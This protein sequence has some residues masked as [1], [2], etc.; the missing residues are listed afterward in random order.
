MQTTATAPV[1]GGRPLGGGAFDDVPAAAADGFAL[2]LALLAGG[3]S[4]GPGLSS[5]TVEASRADPPAVS[6]A[7]AG[8]T[9]GG[10]GRAAALPAF[11]GSVLAADGSMAGRDASTAAG[12]TSG[13]LASAGILPL[14]A[15]TA[16]AP[17]LAE[18]PGPLSGLE[19]AASA[20]GASPEAPLLFAAAAERALAAPRPAPTGGDRTSPAIARAFLDPA[21]SAAEERSPALADRGQAATFAASAGDARAPAATPTGTVE[22]GPA[23]AVGAEAG[24]SVATPTAFVEPLPAAETAPSMA[25]TTVELAESGAAAATAGPTVEPFVAPSAERRSSVDPAHSADGSPAETVAGRSETA[26]PTAVAIGSRPARAELDPGAPARRATLREGSAPT[27]RVHEGGAGPGRSAASAEPVSASHAVARAALD[28]PPVAP[29]PHG[30]QTL[31]LGRPA[32]LVPTYPAP[33]APQPP[34][35]QI[36]AT[37]LQRAH[38]P[39]EQLQLRL[40]PAE[41]GTIEITV[42]SGERRRARAVLL[43]DRVE[44][45]E[46]L[47]REQRTLERILEASGLELEPGG[48]ELGLRREERG[49]ERDGGRPSFAPEPA[50][51][52]RA[53]EPITAPRVSS[54]RLLDLSV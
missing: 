2:L 41:L 5:V 15:T 54:L 38:G 11:P 26:E 35:V 7:L 53:P 37:I 36:A 10:E 28:Q 1:L 4:T 23:S 40:E 45:L 13:G 8:Q 29:I 21:V 51:A 32:E 18:Q 9:G 27:E 52:D 3:A 14:P 24:A 42:A 30:P 50:R 16:E 47:Q 12:A 31:A 33:A 34:A 19:T 39:I 25:G 17:I 49:S 22:R 43:A 48:L 20:E 6:S 46:L 44:T